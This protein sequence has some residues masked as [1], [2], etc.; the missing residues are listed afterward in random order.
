MDFVFFVLGIIGSII[1]AFNS[2]VLGLLIAAM[3]FFI[4]G[5]ICHVADAKIR[6][7]GNIILAF[8]E[9][10][11]NTLKELEQKK[12]RSK[13]ENKEKFEENIRAMKELFKQM[14]MDDEEDKR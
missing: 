2:D 5:S 7:G 12:N 13:M 3:V 11:Q 14:G 8:V 9:A 10:A 1:F 4:C 6:W